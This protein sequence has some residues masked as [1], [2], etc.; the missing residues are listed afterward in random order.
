M[1]EKKSELHARIAT[2]LCILD[3]ERALLI[4]RHFIA[5]VKKED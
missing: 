1:I 5:K 2:E 3:K 4:F